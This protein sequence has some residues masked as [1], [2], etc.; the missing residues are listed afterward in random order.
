M[1]NGKNCLAEHTSQPQIL[2]KTHSF[3]VN[4]Q[5]FPIEL[6]KCNYLTKDKPV[7]QDTEHFFYFRYFRAGQPRKPSCQLVSS[8]A[9]PRLELLELLLGSSGLCDLEDVE[10]HCLAE[11]SALSDGN[12]V[13]DGDVSAGKRRGLLEHNPKVTMAL[14]F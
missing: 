7:D 6:Y 9:H 1:D 10:P 2:R 3:S 4:W 12:N 8:P 5:R 13:S 14:L 11:G